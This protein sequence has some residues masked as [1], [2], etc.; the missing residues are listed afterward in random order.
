MGEVKGI[1]LDQNAIEVLGW[2]TVELNIINERMIGIVIGN[3]S[4]CASCGSSFTTLPTAAK[5]A[6]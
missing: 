3:I 2:P 5:S 1:M 4:D 6:A